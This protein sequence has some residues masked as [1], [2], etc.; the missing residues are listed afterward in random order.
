MFHV[1]LSKCSA[2]CWQ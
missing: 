2:L 1:G